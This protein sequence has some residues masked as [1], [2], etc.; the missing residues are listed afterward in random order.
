[1]NI[2][3]VTELPANAIV[4]DWYYLK[5]GDYVRHFIVSSQGQYIEVKGGLHTYKF[6]IGAGAPPTN[7]EVK[8]LTLDQT[9][10]DDGLISCKPFG[11]Q[12]IDKAPTD[13]DAD[14]IPFNPVTGTIDFSS[15]GMYDG[16]KVLLTM[17]KTISP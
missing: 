9:L 14:E 16:M 2:H 5:D 1:M 11:M 3:T 12:F 15:Y 17:L 6:Y 8:P 10:Q 13:F 7:Y 4:D